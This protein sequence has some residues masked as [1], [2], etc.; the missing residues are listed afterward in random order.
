MELADRLKIFISYLGISNQSFEKQCGISGGTVSR[1]TSKSY[2][3][4]FDRISKAFPI[5]NIE[6]LLTGEG[7]MLIPREKVQILGAGAQLNGAGASGNVNA[8]TIADS[9]R[10]AELEAEVKIRDARIAD[11]KEIISEKDARIAEKDARIA[12]L[13]ERIE[14]LK[15]R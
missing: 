9:D 15:M 4:T 6:W 1:L 2:R 7:E 13:K 11:L 5:L 3:K 14:D 8:S 12:D 10:V